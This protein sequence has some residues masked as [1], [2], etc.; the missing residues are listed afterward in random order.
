MN[1]TIS[2]Q[3]ANDQMA[4]SLSLTP[5]IKLKNSNWT[6][7]LNDIDPMAGLIATEFGTNKFGLLDE[8]VSVLSAVG[9]ASVIVQLR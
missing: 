2:A 1:T 6:I 5:I 8:A 7:E 3:D 4:F 9:Y